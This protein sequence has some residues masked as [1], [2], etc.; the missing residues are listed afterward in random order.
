MV[1]LNL[2]LLL[3]FMLTEIVGGFI[4]NALAPLLKWL[5]GL[6]ASTKTVLWRRCHVSFHL[7]YHKNGEY[8]EGVSGRSQKV[9][10]AGRDATPLRT[11][12]WSEHKA[13][14]GDKDIHMFTRL[15]GIEEKLLV[16]VIGL[17]NM[18]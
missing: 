7:L 4:S 11:L 18:D 8:D 12:K 5:W 17:G 14:T 15:R 2:T 1:C 10:K 13:V 16:E 9:C 6:K 3:H